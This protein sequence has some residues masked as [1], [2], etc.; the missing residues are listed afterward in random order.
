MLWRDELNN[1]KQEGNWALG[2]STE[3]TVISSSGESIIMPS[4]CFNVDMQCCLE[5]ENKIVH[6]NQK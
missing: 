2:R 4:I 5:S 6:L 1:I 3:T